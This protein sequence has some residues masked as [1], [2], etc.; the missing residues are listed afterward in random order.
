M[1]DTTFQHEHGELCGPPLR[2]AH[3]RLFWRVGLIFV[4]A[5]ET[6]GN[7]WITWRGFVETERSRHKWNSIHASHRTLFMFF[8]N[9]RTAA[10][11]KVVE[12]WMKPDKRQ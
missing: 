7:K 1:L 11:G 10:D 6:A 4:G 8:I 12:F 3:C 5:M 2:P 9:R